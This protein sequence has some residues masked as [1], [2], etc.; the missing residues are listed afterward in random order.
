MMGRCCCTSSRTY[1]TALGE[2]H[3]QLK[4]SLQ[5]I[6][7]KRIIWIGP[8]NLIMASI[9]TPASANPLADGNTRRPVAK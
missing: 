1:N 8:S 3:P 2:R 4:L 7:F 6:P 9:L 5:P